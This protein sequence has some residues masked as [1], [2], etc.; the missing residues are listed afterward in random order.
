MRLFRTVDASTPLAIL[1]EE[2]PLE[3]LEV[4]KAL[5]ATAINPD[6]KTLT[7]SAVKT[8]HTAGY[9][10]YPWTV[11]TPKAI[12]QMKRLGVDGIITDYPERIRD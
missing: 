8:M 6:Y 7:A 4:A 12:T 1:T 9:K 5:T 10:V 11:N 2:N 3:A